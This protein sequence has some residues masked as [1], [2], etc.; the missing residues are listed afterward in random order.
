MKRFIDRSVGGLHFDPP[1]RLAR[2]RQ[3]GNRPAWKR[4]YGQQC[5]LTRTCPNCSITGSN[6]KAIIRNGKFER[7]A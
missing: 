2:R 5:A 7:S 3:Y 4:R 1:C 6:K